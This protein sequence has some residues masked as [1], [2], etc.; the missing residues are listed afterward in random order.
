MRRIAANAV[1]NATANAAAAIAMRSS[2]ARFSSEYVELRLA[3]RR[4]A[5]ARRVTTLDT[6]THV[7]TEKWLGV[8]SASASNAIRNR[9]TAKSTPKVRGAMA[10]VTRR[11]G[12][13]VCTLDNPCLAAK[14]E[15][16][17]KRAR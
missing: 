10:V 7:K 9:P 2:G 8:A 13:P 12:A 17:G 14:G 16:L 11:A 1:G 3:S 6:V 5:P 15:G 4:P